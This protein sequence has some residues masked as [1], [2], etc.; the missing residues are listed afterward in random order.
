MDL[1][2]VLISGKS[3]TPGEQIGENKDS[4]K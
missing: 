3:R 2:R 4:S 1:K